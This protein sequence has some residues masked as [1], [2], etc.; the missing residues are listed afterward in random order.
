MMSGAPT[1]GRTTESGGGRHCSEP[2]HRRS[3]RSRSQTPTLEQIPEGLDHTE[4]GWIDLFMD[5]IDRGGEVGEAVLLLARIGDTG[6]LD[7]LRYLQEETLEYS[8]RHPDL[9]WRIAPYL[10]VWRDR[11]QRSE[12]VG[13]MPDPTMRKQREPPPAA[14]RPHIYSPGGL[15]PDLEPV[16]GGG[17]L[18]PHGASRRSGPAPHGSPTPGPRPRHHVVHPTDA[19][20]FTDG[21]PSE[22]GATRIHQIRAGVGDG[23]VQTQLVNQQVAA[24]KQISATLAHVSGRQESESKIGEGSLAHLRSNAKYLTYLARGCDT[25]EV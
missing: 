1:F 8:L 13:R 16:G 17:S 11:I 10:S 22:P 19:S 21:D 20:P 12:A 18:L 14:P 5:E 4:P 9:V 2:H 7:I 15:R 23:D 3:T 6:E 25:L 24:L